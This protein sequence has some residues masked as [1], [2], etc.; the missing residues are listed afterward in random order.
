MH[1]G[2][3]TFTLCGQP[4]QVVRLYMSFVTLRRLREIVQ[5]NPTTPRMQRSRAI[6]HTWFGLFPVRSPL[7]RESLLLS[8]PGS[9]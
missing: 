4:F 1:F 5:Q 9:T 7:L 3:V 6:R 2:Y 8:F